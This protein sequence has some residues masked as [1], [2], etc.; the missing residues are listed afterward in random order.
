[1]SEN[2]NDFNLA[3]EIAKLDEDYVEEKTELDEAIESSGDVF[4]S[5]EEVKEEIE[6]SVVDVEAKEDTEADTETTEETVEFTPNFGYK[7]KDEEREIPEEFR[8]F[9]K[10]QASQDR[11]I[12]LFTKADGLE[13]VKE[14]RQKLQEQ[15]DVQ[16]EQYT[17]ISKAMDVFENMSSTKDVKGLLGAADF[18]AEDVLNSLDEE[19]KLKHVM[20]LLKRQESPEAQ[21]EYNR[22]MEVEREN[23]RLKS[24]LNTQTT[25]IDTRQMEAERL[26]IET[27]MA[28]PEVQKWQSE[29]DE[30]AGKDTFIEAVAEVGMAYYAKH[31]K[32]MTMDEAVNIVKNRYGLGQTA[33]EPAPAKSSVPTKVIRKVA[34]ESSM[35]DIES[36]GESPVDKGIN[37]ID[38]II[39]ERERYFKLKKG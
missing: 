24:Q 25:Q 10:D 38:D 26:E 9:I 34:T 6:E 23:L 3:D 20:E 12:D 5:K 22:A 1:M 37:S 29:L 18:S 7:V 27:T 2:E 33:V 36:A 19:T 21:R 13:T 17:K 39:R 11:F 16:V 31:K 4:E 28:K 30:R 8:E 32:D 35:P 14:S 15:Y